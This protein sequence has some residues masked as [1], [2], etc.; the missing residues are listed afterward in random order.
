M[1]SF[2]RFLVR[3]SLNR[4]YSPCQQLLP[5]EGHDSLILCEAVPTG[6]LDVVPVE[7]LG[8]HH[9]PKGQDKD[10]NVQQENPL[11]EEEVGG[12]PSPKMPLD[13]LHVAPP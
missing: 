11:Q 13:L 1:Y 2:K 10:R 12:H 5:G 7:D 9:E 4:T 3:S 6:H 8:H